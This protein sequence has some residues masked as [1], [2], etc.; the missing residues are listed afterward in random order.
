MPTL[1]HDSAQPRLRSS[2]AASRASR[3]A[4]AACRGGPRRRL[5]GR[6]HAEGGVHAEDAPCGELVGAQAGRQL[7]VVARRE[8][9]RPVGHLQRAVRQEAAYSDDDARRGLATTPPRSRQPVLRC[10]EGQASPPALPQASGA[11]P[12]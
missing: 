1:G 10:A 8:Q 7:V 12:R 11:P 9:P 4:A 3:A 5:G 2:R 6:Q